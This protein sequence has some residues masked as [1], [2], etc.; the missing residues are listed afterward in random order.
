M[1]KELLKPAVHGPNCGC[2]VHRHERAEATAKAQGT[3]PK[4]TPPVKPEPKVEP[5][6]VVKVRKVAAVSD[7]K[8]AVSDGATRTARWRGKQD[9]EVLKQR[10]RDAVQRCRAKKAGKGKV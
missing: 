6:V 3:T 1:G 10:N 5:A 2:I 4:P 7:A 9:P 8:S